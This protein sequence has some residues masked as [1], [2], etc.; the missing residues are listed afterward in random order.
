M[1][2]VILCTFSPTFVSIAQAY[3]SGGQLVI[4]LTDR[5]DMEEENHDKAKLVLRRMTS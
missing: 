5:I 4:G 3:F 1:L 2:Q